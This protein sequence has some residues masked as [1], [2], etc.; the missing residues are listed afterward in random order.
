MTCA[1]CAASK[2]AMAS[3]MPRLA[4]VT[5]ATLPLRSKVL[6]ML[7]LGEVPALHKDASQRRL[8][9]D[10]FATLAQVVR[11]R[12]EGGEHGVAGVAFLEALVDLLHDAGQAEQ[13]IDLVE[14]EVG[15]APACALGVVVD[16]FLA[17]QHARCIGGLA[18]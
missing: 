11:K 18:A 6:G 10:A 2:R 15:H 13:A 4:P 3:P 7:I 17:C 5:R 9:N 14:I 1:P 8:G 16:D 12:P